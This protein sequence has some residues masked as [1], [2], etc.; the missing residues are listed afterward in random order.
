MPLEVAQE[1]LTYVVEGMSLPLFMRQVSTDADVSIVWSQTLDQ[2][3]ISLSVE[4]VDVQHLMKVVA[5]R[6]GVDLARYGNLY[7]LGKMEKTDRVSYVTKVSRISRQDVMAVLDSMKSDIGLV[8]VMA[9]GVLVVADRLEVV[10]EIERVLFKIES[11]NVSVWMVQLYVVERVN[12]T[13][14]EKGVKIDTDINVAAVLSET[15]TT[16][17]QYMGKA[18][19]NFRWELARSDAQVIAQ[20]LLLLVDGGKSTLKKV[21]SV[22]VP[23]YTTSSEGAV[24]VSGYDYIDSG[25]DLSAEVRDWG[26]G[27]ANFQYDLSMGEITGYVGDVPVQV[28]NQLAGETVVRCGGVYLLGSLTRQNTSHQR[29]GLFGLNFKEKKK[30]GIVRIWARVERVSV[31]SEAPVR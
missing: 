3:E 20:P 1:K 21:E 25:F 12:E 23:R 24:S 9:D 14:A 7:Y 16:D 31:Q 19:A 4:A 28:K 5:R 18:M 2:S 26:N 11:M 17:L 22:P 6:L 13:S 15:A 30:D 27:L 10:A 8:T 29:D